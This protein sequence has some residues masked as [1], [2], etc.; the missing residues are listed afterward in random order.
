MKK[1]NRYQKT[2]KA[3]LSSLL[4]IYRSEPY[5]ASLHPSRL[6]EHSKISLST[7]YRHYKTV[8]DIFIFYEKKLTTRF[9]NIMKRRGKSN[10]RHTL[11]F[12]LLFICKHQEFF[13]INFSRGDLR[14][15]RQIFVMIRPKIE[16]TYA[17]PEDSEK[18]FDICFYEFYG[19][20]KQWSLRAFSERELNCI[21]GDVLYLLRSAKSR[22]EKII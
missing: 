14:L 2:E 22:L 17:W 4:R 13:L 10:I 8:D 3:I 18:L 12:A 16:K 7:F 6:A 9:T 20:L 5:L 11:R 15:V 1:D 19:L 21:L